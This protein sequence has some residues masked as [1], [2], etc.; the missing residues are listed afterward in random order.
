MYTDAC[1]HGTVLFAWIDPF[2][3]TAVHNLSFWFLFRHF[4]EDLRSYGFP[5]LKKDCFFFCYEMNYCDE[6]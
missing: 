6:S 1:L 2:S 4:I 5:G 3:D